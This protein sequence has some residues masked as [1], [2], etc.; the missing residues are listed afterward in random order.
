[1]IHLNEILKNSP[2][3]ILESF[4]PEF[5]NAFSIT[6]FLRNCQQIK[7]TRKILPLGCFFN[8]SAFIKF[9]KKLIYNKL[10]WK[11]G[12]ISDLS[13]FIEVDVY[14][15]DREKLKEGIKLYEPS[16][17][18]CKSGSIYLVSYKLQGP[19]ANELEFNRDN[20]LFNY[21]KLLP[22]TTKK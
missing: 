9:D 10:N 11:R 18:F 12:T 21:K 5:Y 15:K 8:G 17:Q 16:I 14:K 1:M 2:F 3:F 20:N 6:D 4:I 7:F 19:P 22:L 13:A